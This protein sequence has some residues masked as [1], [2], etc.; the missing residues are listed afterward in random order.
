MPSV[1][2][3]DVDQQKFVKAL[4]VFL[5]KSGKMKVPEWVDIVKTGTHKELAPFD[6]DWFYVRCAALARHLYVR[7]PVGVGTV[8]KIFGGLKRN[9]TTPAH[10]SV[11]SGSVARRA[12]Q[13]LEG[14]KILEKDPSGGRRLSSQGRRDL[15]RI[16]AQIKLKI[17][18]LGG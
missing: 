3:K 11:G 17:W 6:E 13:S 9:G 15:D 16:A 5:K 18:L 4:S 14:L 12:I 7:S 1:S 10:F 2:V 8:R